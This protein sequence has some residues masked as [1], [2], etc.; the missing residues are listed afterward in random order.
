M[1]ELQLVK[2]RFIYDT[3]GIIGL[4]KTYQQGTTTI[5]KTE[6]LNFSYMNVFTAD[7]DHIMFT[8]GEANY[9][10]LVGELIY[11]PTEE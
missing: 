4:I 1:T 2:A 3:I 11:S 10:N 5:K 9:V 7:G 6:L 8:S